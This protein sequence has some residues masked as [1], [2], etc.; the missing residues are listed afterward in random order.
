MPTPEARMQRSLT[1][2]EL[3]VV[4]SLLC[5]V[6]TIVFMVGVVYGD[7]KRTTER[8]QLLEPKVEAVANRMERVDANVQFLVDA[9]REK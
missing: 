9:D 4:V 3:G 2:A 6:G 1:I 7:L 5:S 8:V